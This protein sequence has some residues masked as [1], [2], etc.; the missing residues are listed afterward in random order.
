M[1]TLWF[2]PNIKKFAQKIGKLKK[3]LYHLTVRECDTLII[4]NVISQ[5]Y[6]SAFHNEKIY[7]ISI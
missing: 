6:R 4:A 2:L 1:S 5:L 3:I 7:I